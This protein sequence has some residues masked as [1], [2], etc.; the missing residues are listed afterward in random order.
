[1]LCAQ[2][3]LYVAT[4]FAVCCLLFAVCCLLFAVC[5]KILSL[6]Y[7]LTDTSVSYPYIKNSTI[8]F[9]LAKFPF[10]RL[11]TEAVAAVVARIYT[12]KSLTD[13]SRLHEV[14]LADDIPEVYETLYSLFQ[15]EEF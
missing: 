9:S 11:A 5:C 13:L 10:V 15:T 1:M 7:K 2:S 4:P 3:K 12:G 6:L 8:T 14:V